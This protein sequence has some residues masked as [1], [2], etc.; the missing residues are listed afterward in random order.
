MHEVYGT[1][2]TQERIQAMIRLILGL[3]VLPVIAYF[4][5]FLPFLAFDLTPAWT[6][7]EL[8][9]AQ[10]KMLDGQKRVV[11]KHPY[12]SHWTSWPLMTRPIWYVFDKEPEP[13]FVRGVLMIGNP[14]V[15]WPGLVALVGCGIQWLFNQK[16]AR[17]LAGM[18]LCFWATL[19]FCWGTGLRVVSFYYYYY[20]AALFLSLALAACFQWLEEHYSKPSQRRILLITQAAYFCVVLGLFVYFLPILAAFKI[21]GDQFRQW[22]WMRSWI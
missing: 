15:V 11:G 12:H 22:M 6:W 1:R 21:P 4:S 5:T 8:W 17:S 10:V 18:I 20:P 3:G 16:Q 9:N 14:A 2:P 19:Y 7:S 13:G